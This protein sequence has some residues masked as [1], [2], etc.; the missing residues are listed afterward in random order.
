MNP[1]NLQN[2]QNNITLLVDVINK[3]SEE[4]KLEKREIFQKLNQLIKLAEEFANATKLN[5]N[6]SN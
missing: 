3:L 6:E 1:S 5:K 2:N 4:N